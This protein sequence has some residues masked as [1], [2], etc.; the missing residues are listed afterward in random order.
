MAWTTSKEVLQ[1]FP[2]HLGMM[3]D[4]HMKFTNWRQESSWDMWQ[5]HDQI[6][7]GRYRSTESPSKTSG[8][9]SS[10]YFSSCSFFTSATTTSFFSCSF[11]LQ[12]LWIQVLPQRGHS[13]LAMPYD[14]GTALASFAW[15]S[16]CQVLINPSLLQLVLSSLPSLS[17]LVICVDDQSGTWL[18]NCLSWPS[19]NHKYW[20]L[21]NHM[22]DNTNNTSTNYKHQCSFSQT[23]QSE[24]PWLASCR[25]NVCRTIVFDETK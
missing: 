21:Q 22:I 11:W 8:W 1:S 17:H 9:S 16:H 3:M 14:F 10:P 15:W 19:G 24:T 12:H 18:I 5:C 23:L 25:G 20:L 13:L 2:L 4:L 7:K 6:L